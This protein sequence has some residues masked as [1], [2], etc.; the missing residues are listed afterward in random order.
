MSPRPLDALEA[1]IRAR[2][3]APGAES[4]TARL[5][6]GGLAKVGPKVL[7]EAAELVEAAGEPGD[8]GRA[9]AIYEAADLIY[10]SLVLLRVA[11]IDLAEVEAE[12]ARRFGVSGLA[13]KAARGAAAAIA[14]P[15][16]PQGDGG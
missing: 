13:E 14:S 1:T 11:G 9:H 8:A 6:A 12:L 5:L 15:P 3:A 2:A 4:Y 10:H 7:E 16:P